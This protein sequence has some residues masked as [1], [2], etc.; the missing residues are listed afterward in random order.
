LLALF[1]DPEYGSVMLLWNVGW[2]ST[3]YKRYIPE[4]WILV[5]S[6][7]LGNALWRDSW[8]PFLSQEWKQNEL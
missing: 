4:D 3:D 6:W 8:E 2:R 7:F 1:F 5:F